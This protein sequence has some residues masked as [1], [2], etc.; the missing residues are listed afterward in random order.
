MVLNESNWYSTCYKIPKANGAE[1]DETEVDCLRIGPSF[2]KLEYNHGYNEEESCS[3]QIG[4]QVDEKA[5]A[6]L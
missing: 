3:W 5:G 1:G 4:H 6:V 2:F